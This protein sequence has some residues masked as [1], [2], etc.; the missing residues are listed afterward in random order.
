[1]NTETPAIANARIAV[2]AASDELNTV[3]SGIRFARANPA[4]VTK[5]EVETLLA[6][7]ATLT[8]RIDSLMKAY[9]KAVRTAESR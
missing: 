7:S 3:L 6:R 5:A 1:M 9:D 4:E 8:A 2:L